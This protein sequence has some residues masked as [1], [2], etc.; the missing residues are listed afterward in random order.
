MGDT[1]R[2]HQVAMVIGVL[3]LGVIVSHR[4]H[5]QLAW[6]IPYC[7]VADAVFH[8]F[9]GTCRQCRA[10]CHKHDTQQLQCRDS[11]HSPIVLK[12]SSKGIEN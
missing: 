10:Q 3:Q 2:N 6:L 4:D 5:R 9:Q 1:C 11:F 8:E 12:S 7:R